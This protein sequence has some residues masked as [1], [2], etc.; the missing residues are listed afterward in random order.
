MS[1]FGKAVRIQALA[2]LRPQ[3]LGLSALNIL[4]I[5]ALWTFL[6]RRLTG[7]VEGMDVS[8]GHYLI[9]GSLVGFSAMVAYQIA[10]EIYNEYMAGTLLRVRTLPQGVK[11]WSTAKLITSA[12]VIL[13]S[14]V[15]LLLATLFFI[16]GFALT[17]DK[18]ALAIPFLILTLAATA[19]L[20]FIIGALTRT[21]TALIIGMLLFMGFMAIS[22]IFFPLDP[23][24]GWLQAVSKVL[25][26]YH[27]GVV[28]RWVFLGGAENV[29]LSSGVLAAWFFLGMIVARKAIVLS[30]SKVSLGTVAR[31]QQNLKN[32]MGI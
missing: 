11:I 3:L 32:T 21:A 20:G 6:G 2:D 22:G 24:P 23:L 26:I 4:I 31:A 10:A 27:G 29:A 1:H 16:P 12:G 18:V 17:W 7:L 9:A 8:V 15:L 13:V 25:P 14:Q 28:S 19:P 30:F 5:P